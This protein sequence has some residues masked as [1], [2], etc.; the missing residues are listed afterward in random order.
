MNTMLW[1]GGL[2]FF[3]CLV[4]VCGLFYALYFFVSL[5][6]RR[7]ER[8]RLFLDLLETGLKQGHSLE[9]TILS[10]AEARD[11]SLGVRFHLLA[12]YLE[13][14]MGLGQALE[15]V[16]H[17]LPPQ[18]PAMLKAALE[19]GVLGKILFACR[20]QLKDGVAQVWKA[21]NYLALVALVISPAWIFIFW[22]LTIFVFPKY[23]A[24]AADLEATSTGLLQLL[25]QYKELLLAC[26][27]A[28]L[29]F[30]Y[31]GLFLFVGGPRAM[32][33]LETIAPTL[34]DYVVFRLP[35][36]RKR[37][38]RNFSSMLAVLLDAGLPEAKAVGL[39]AQS[40]ANRIFQRRADGV[41]ADL[42]RGVKLTEAVQRL[43]DSG[44][45]HWRLTNA[46]HGG[47]GFLSAL[48]GWH[49]ALEA[50]A[51]Q[52]EQAVAQLITTALVLLNGLLV[53][54]LAVA[55]FQILIAIIDAGVLW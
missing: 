18:I 8:V 35:W 14:G 46:A 33:W 30:F 49:D 2:W 28:L 31:F 6:L 32:S 45:F 21:Q 9:R 10:A 23:L 29:A 17:F 1:G 47:G 27:L 5:P 20:E 50:K 25:A 11:R 53:G 34:A 3:V 7:Q 43:D 19:A 54:M 52:E 42:E 39:A 41:A 38:Q 44:E 40:A 24:V 51:F 55:V 16:P 36:R 13:G 12:A 26:Q 37:M 22:V 48:S 4:P 15:K